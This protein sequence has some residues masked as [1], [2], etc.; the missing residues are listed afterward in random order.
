MNTYDIK[1]YK[2]LNTFATPNGIVIFGGS[3]AKNIPLCELKQA[4]A[5]EPDMYNRSITS[6]S[7]RDAGLVYEECILPLAPETILLHIG[8]TDLDFFEKNPTGFDTEY[9]A[10]LTRIK[11]HTPTCRIAIVS[12]RNY[13]NNPVITD[14]N[15]HLRYIAD[16]EQCE[17][18]DIAEKKVWNP[19]NTKDMVSFVYSTGFVRPLHI[20]R[21]LYDLIKILFC[22]E[23]D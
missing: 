4:F 15:T 16:S 10:L 20:K 11:T 13:D 14:L 23:T 8:E 21:P 17:Y 6:L 5:I 2:K 12:L 22:C 7:I 9:H 1:K 19:K 18:G 3:Q